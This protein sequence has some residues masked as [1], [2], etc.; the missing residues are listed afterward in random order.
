MR[1]AYPERSYGNR[2][3]VP[4]V[5]QTILILCAVVVVSFLITHIFGDQFLAMKAIPEKKS[6]R[7][8]TP[9]QPA[10]DSDAG[11]C[12]DGDFGL[13]CEDLDVGPQTHP[14]R[15]RRS[16]SPPE[17]VKYEDFSLGTINTN[18]AEKLCDQK[19]AALCNGC[20]QEPQHDPVATTEVDVVAAQHNAESS[21][22]IEEEFDNEELTGAEPIMN[23]PPRLPVPRGPDGFN[24]MTWNV[25]ADHY[26]QQRYFPYATG[27]ALQWEGRR[28]AI[29]RVVLSE[30]PDVLCLQEVQS[31][32]ADMLNDHMEWFMQWLRKRG[33]GVTYGRKMGVTQVSHGGPQSLLPP[34]WGP[35]DLK[36]I[37]IGNLT[38]WKKSEFDLESSKVVPL[39]L[40]VA[41]ACADKISAEH[42]AARYCQ[43]LV[44]TALRHKSTGNLLLVGNTH[45]VAPRGDSDHERK[46]AQIQQMT[47]GFQAL[48]KEVQAYA[49]DG[50]R[51]GVVLLGDFNATP[52]SELYELLSTKQVCDERMRNLT[53]KGLKGSEGKVKKVPFS[54]PN[55][56][57]LHLQSV[58]TVLGGEEPQFTNYT[59]GFKGCLDYITFEPE[60]LRC[61]GVGEFPSE[62]ILKRELA[63]P[64]S[65]LPSDHLPVMCRLEF[66]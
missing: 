3:Q 33:Y 55:T 10:T 61:A 12:T 13:Q 29:K 54:S 46:L 4:E 65:D 9:V 28:E 8:E 50:V 44:A 30:L 24:V 47:A 18:A 62:G 7:K 48:A 14:K 39:A 20:S 6:K 59:E 27:A 38:A 52:D 5:V 2:V 40:Q 22:E 15:N 42:L 57:G 45:L 43:V 53:E 16:V 17:I 56:A 63:L 23:G 64:N 21:P 31:S 60:G 36:G 41:S 66:E 34:E 19:D 58:H 35:S 1:H 51:P 49:V 25:L 32:T 11:R 37:Q 26:A